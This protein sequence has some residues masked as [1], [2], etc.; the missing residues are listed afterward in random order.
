MI[1]ALQSR[2]LDYWTKRR[3]HL[4]RMEEMR[5]LKA[6]LYYCPK[7]RRVIFTPWRRWMSQYY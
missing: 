5:L 3:Q 6:V 7:R 1:N 2:I 4:E